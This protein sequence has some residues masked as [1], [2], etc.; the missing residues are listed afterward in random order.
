MSL[1]LIRAGVILLFA[2]LL[3]SCGGDD[4]GGGG[5]SARL[6]V[7][8]THI[9]VAAQPGDVAPAGF[10]HLTVTD[11]PEDDL[12][13][14]TVNAGSGL[15]RFEV[16]DTIQTEATLWITFQRPHE[17]QNGTYH[18]SIEVHV[19]TDASCAE[20]I[21][22]SPV[23]I[24]TVYSVSGGITATLDRNAI[25][26]ATDNH[27][28]DRQEEIVH[29]TLDRAPAY[30]LYTRAEYTPQGIA[31]VSTSILTP[32]TADTSISFWPGSSMSPGTFDGTV[33]LTLCYEVSC[34]RQLIGSPFT[35]S[36]RMIVNIGAEPGYT[37]LVVASRTA[38]AH[39]VID[40]E[41]SRALNAVVMVGRYPVNALYV[42][43]VAT[44]IEQ[45]RTL[46]KAPA[47]VS[48]SPDGLTAAVGHDALIS[49]VDL[50]TVGQ[51][52][53][54]TPKRV[55]VATD[56]M[57]VVLDGRGR[58]HVIAR[59]DQ[60]QPIHTVDIATNTE[61]L[62]AGFYPF[63]PMLARLHPSG[64]YMYGA[65]NE[66]GSQYLAKWDVRGDQAVGMY[67][68]PSDL[69]FQVCGNLWFNERGKTI[70]TACGNTFSS[71]KKEATDMTYTGALEL[72][73]SDDYGWVIL[74]LSQSDAADEIALV[75]AEI[76]Q[77]IYQSDSQECY[78][79][80][81]LYES[82][83]LNRQAVFSI[84]PLAVDG[85][86][87]AERGLF[88]FHDATSSRKVMISRLKGMTNPKKEY[89]LSLID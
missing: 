8:T 73:P 33:T 28:D 55:N 70:Y 42:Y 46:V 9:S 66:I 24:E 40:A 58:V 77:C 21:A 69:A 71:T 80:L 76:Y 26:F 11:P 44:G 88:V 64:D 59:G 67:G 22:G 50:A 31:D 53:A 30:D 72:S 61:K 74:S 82:D 39:D 41:F 27:A 32:T 4:N 15:D 51:S 10:V 63:P 52:G 7:N 49:V 13:I 54:P 85:T 35:I 48:I 78:T 60:W 38:L 3:Q 43:D 65:Q 1:A 62:S 23:T 86:T 14:A 5:N 37:P 17:L 12:F 84:A 34:Q 36:T 29:A 16:N 83:F 19:C 87:Y 47:A 20:E 2:M 6:S 81:A 57:D 89:Y 18:A 75:E 45:R 79:H 68:P 25:E 56:V